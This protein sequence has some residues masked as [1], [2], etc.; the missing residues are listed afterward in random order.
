[1]A[2]TFNTKLHSVGIECRATN[3]LKKGKALHFLKNYSQRKIAARPNSAQ[4]K[5][6]L[7]AAWY[8]ISTIFQK[9][10]QTP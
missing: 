3:L 4:S 5:S 9:Q 6:L 2:I 7:T 10:S 8:S 1:M